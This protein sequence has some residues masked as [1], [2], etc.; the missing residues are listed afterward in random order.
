MNGGDGV[1]GSVVGGNALH[2]CQHDL[3]SPILG[4]FTGL[5]LDR[6]GESDGVALRLLAN[7]FEELGL[8][9]GRRHAADALEGSDVVLLRPGQF[10]AALLELAFTIQK[11]S[12]A[13]LEYV[14]PH[15]QLLVAR[16][17]PGL[18]KCEFGALGP[19]LDLRL[20]QEAH[21]FV[22]RRE[23]QLLLLGP[24]LG[25]DSSRLLLCGLDGRVGEKASRKKANDH[26]HDKGSRSGDG[27]K[28][29]F[30]MNLPPTR[31]CCA[32]GGTCIG[33]EAAP[34]PRLVSSSGARPCGCR[35]VND[36]D[37]RRR[38][39][40]GPATACTFRH[41]VYGARRNR[42][43]NPCIRAGPFL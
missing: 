29:E 34:N 41:V 8:R 37:W 40:V 14:G 27:R 43:R 33:V 9:F 1:F 15:I 19:S 13:L 12:V 30:H 28:G 6:L 23:D 2:R 21:L 10:L 24:G 16:K 22:L 17:Q 20:T 38:W 7:R 3:T 11:L 26:A 25:D 18:E 35:V 4:L 36:S 32:T 5:A 42:S 39:N 31:S